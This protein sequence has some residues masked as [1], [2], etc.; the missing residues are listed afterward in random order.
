MMAIIGILAALT[1]EAAGFVQKKGARDKATAEIAALSA[2]L[3]SYKADN[4]DYPSGMTINSN[5]T[6]PAIDPSTG[7]Q[8]LTA[9]N[10]SLVGALMPSSGKVYFE[11]SPKRLATTSSSTTTNPN[12]SI[13]TNGGGTS[14]LDP[15]GNSYGYCYGGSVAQ[16]YNTNNGNAVNVTNSVS[17]SY[18]NGASS[19]DLW[20]TAGDSAGGTP[21][22]ATWIKNW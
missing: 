5:Y 18:S 12:G 10:S 2:A 4:G 3:E 11:F 14:F 15:W 16:T 8:S 13:T 1:L 7:K 19:F 21:N 9:Q 22:P 17:G 6:Q 20:S